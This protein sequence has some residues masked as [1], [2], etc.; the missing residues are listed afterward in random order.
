M[1]VKSWL[2]VNIMYNNSVSNNKYYTKMN[3]SIDT[4]VGKIA[5]T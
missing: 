1:D 4:P 5:R 3:G 2:D